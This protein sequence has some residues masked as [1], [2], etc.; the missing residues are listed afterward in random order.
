MVDR[1]GGYFLLSELGLV[2]GDDLEGVQDACQGGLGPD[3]LNRILVED[4][5]NPWDLRDLV[6]RVSHFPC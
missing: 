5:V 6:R 4:V 3:A 2:L 1:T